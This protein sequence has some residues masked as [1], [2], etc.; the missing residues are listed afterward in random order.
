M[1]FFILLVVALAVTVVWQTT[2]GASPYA[3]GATATG[4]VQPP[5]AIHAPS[6]LS[7]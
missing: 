7:D 6:A 5:G 1:R 3:V 4:G 2:I